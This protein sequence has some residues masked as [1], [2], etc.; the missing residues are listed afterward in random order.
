MS[1]MHVYRQLWSFG[2]PLILAKFIQKLP[3]M[4]GASTSGRAKPLAS[5][6]VGIRLQLSFAILVM[7]YQGL[8][9][10]EFIECSSQRGLNEGF[11]YQDF[12]LQAQPG[13]QKRRWVLQIT[14]RLRKN[15]RGNQ[16]NNVTHIL[17]DEPGNPHLCPVTHFCALAFADG[18]FQNLR[19]PEDLNR[20]K[21]GATVRIK[22]SV[23]H[24]SVLR[25]L[26]Q[27]GH[28]S[29]TLVFGADSLNFYLNGL[30]ERAGYRDN[31]TAYAFRRGHGNKLDQMVSSVQR[32]QRM[33]HK[34]D[35]TFQYYI[36]R[37]SGVD[38][39]SIMLGREP[40]QELM[41]HV[42]SM[43]NH[44]DPVAPTR[45]GSRLTDARRSGEPIPVPDQDPLPETNL[46]IK[47]SRDSVCWWNECKFS[48]NS[49]TALATHL[50]D[51]HSLFSAVTL[52]TDV[53]FC[54]EC[55]EWVESKTS[56]DSH[57]EAHMSKLSSLGPFCGQIVRNGVVIVAA[58][59]V[60]CLGKI[61]TGFSRR[62]HQF[63][64]CYALH[65]HIDS[66]LSKV[67][68]WPL[69]CPHPYCDYLSMHVEG[70]WLHLVQSH[71][72]EAKVVRPKRNRPVGQ[73]VDHLQSQQ[74]VDMSDDESAMNQSDSLGRSDGVDNSSLSSVDIADDNMHDLSYGI[75]FLLSVEGAV[76]SSIRAIPYVA[77]ILIGRTLSFRRGD[78]RI[79]NVTCMPRSRSFQTHW[80][81][82]PLEI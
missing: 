29:P 32:R 75:H 35:D 67:K 54:Y 26:D 41:D 59:C 15:H 81:I 7:M 23:K 64:D 69:V 1:E 45:T 79:C 68:D 19:S 6:E 46:H 61:G 49:K 14:V 57:C 2:I 63:A 72:I 18:A 42:R 33:G 70:F 78:A 25:R 53:N 5:V 11:T 50:L 74:G 62:F 16:R 28:V 21:T 51:R 77:Y 12:A 37:I 27:A 38:T 17:T 60:F 10:G 36:S 24:T 9:P 56:W 44:H 4:E 76:A 13:S 34:S 65:A 73:P 39:Q 8:R 52:P 66:H 31:L 55:G 20:V 48:A 71:G 40:R 3:D 43:A 22:D 47:S 80:E 58:K 30:G 82:S